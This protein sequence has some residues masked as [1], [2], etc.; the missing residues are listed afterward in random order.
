MPITF[1]VDHA[2]RLVRVIAS[3]TV[4][5]ETV[6][7]YFDTQGMLKGLTYPRLVE[8]R[9]L[10]ARLTDDEWRE[11]AE[12]LRSLVRPAMLGPAAV[13]V[14]D[15]ETFELVC[16]ISVLVSDVCEL[17]AFEDRLSAEEWLSEQLA[18]SPTVRG[19]C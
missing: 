2:Q 16:M 12:A 5:R 8:C 3:G 18:R 6:T 10:D 15:E 13:V 11:I 9:A 1:T 7:R 17:R 19:F 4:T 14:D